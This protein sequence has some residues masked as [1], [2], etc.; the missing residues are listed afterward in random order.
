M[1]DLA[2]HLV[3]VVHIVVQ[4]DHSYAHA[5]LRGR[6]GLC[7]VH[8]TVGKQIAFQRTGHLLFH[9]FSGS[10][11]IDSHHHTLTDSGMRKLILWHHI[12]AVYAKHEQNQYDEQR[13]GVVLQRPL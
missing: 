6:G 3:F 9:L 13:Y 1:L 2:P 8:L 10:T 7:A 4:L 12:H 5:V 11:G